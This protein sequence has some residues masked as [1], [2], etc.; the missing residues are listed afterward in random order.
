MYSA[1]LMTV[2]MYF[3]NNGL[4]F[5][6]FHDARACPYIMQ[7]VHTTLGRYALKHSWQYP[8]MPDIQYFPFVHIPTQF[9]HSG[10][11][12]FIAVNNVGNFI[13][14]A[15][16]DLSADEQILFSFMVNGISCTL[17]NTHVYRAVRRCICLRDAIDLLLDL[18]SSR[19]FVTNVFSDFRWQFII[20]QRDG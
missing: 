19:S 15:P 20:G 8:Q 11:L 2:C 6:E 9:H 3:S 12:E 17:V 7:Y 14:F 18:P 16:P 10:R 1:M 13:Q 4:K 5:F